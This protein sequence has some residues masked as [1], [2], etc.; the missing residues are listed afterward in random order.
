MSVSRQTAP[1]TV[2]N[3]PADPP[4]ST[5]NAEYMPQLDTLRA[6]AVFAV[7]IHHFFPA[8]RLPDPWAG[9][10]WGQWGV[11]LFFV[12]SGFLITGILLRAKLGIERQEIGS[13]FALRQFY[14]RRFLRIMPIYYL[15]VV[16]GIIFN[17]ETTREI[18]VPL[19]THTLN[20]HMAYEGVYDKVYA[21]FWSLNVE[22]HFYLVWPWLVTFLPRR[23]LIILLLT[24]V[25]MAPLCRI[26]LYEAWGSPAGFILTPSSLDV[27]SMGALLAFARERFGTEGL[28]YQRGLPCVAII[29]LVLVTLV[30][31]PLTIFSW[32]LVDYLWGLGAGL[33]F[34]FIVAHASKGVDG[35]LGWLLNFPGLRYIGKLSYGI[36]LYHLFVPLLLY[37]SFDALGVNIVP[38]FLGPFKVPVFML[39]TIGLAV[40]SWYFIEQPANSLKRYFPMRAAKPRTG[41]LDMAVPAESVP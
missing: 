9:L 26:E 40:A 24:V 31:L 5:G 15:V 6:V 28:F 7:M 41:N 34:F 25:L 8:E 22:E 4:K 2:Q 21:H 35:A 10:P 16:L 12:L 18:T 11:Q 1:V 39:T 33:L 13:L 27:L 14:I 37:Y 23:S 36:Y 20:F 32:Q 3:R 19:L 17:F 30:K 38:L 29:G